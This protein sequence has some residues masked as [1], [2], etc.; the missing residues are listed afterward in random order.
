[1]RP[2]FGNGASFMIRETGQSHKPRNVISE[3]IEEEVRQE[4]GVRIETA[5]RSWSYQELES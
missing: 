1:M 2:L 3:R 4:S 5:T